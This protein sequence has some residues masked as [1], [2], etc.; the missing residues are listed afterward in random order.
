[1]EK[2]AA[3][4]GAGVRGDVA[5]VAGRPGFNPPLDQLPK[6]T[7]ELKRLRGRHWD[8]IR[9]H[10]LGFKNA[11]I[12]QALGCTTQTVSN[13]LQAQICKDAIAELQAQLNVQ[14]SDVQEM[15]ARSAPAVMQELLT[16]FFAGNM[17]DAHRTK[18]GFG[19]MDRAGHGPVKTEI[20]VER[21][22]TAEEMAD[23]K[24]RMELI[25]VKVRPDIE[26]ATI[27]EE[28][29]AGSQA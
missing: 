11:E 20:K 7:W 13:C 6:T 9:Y 29:D 27:I 5:A 10:V 17:Q 23:I 4:Y 26:E 18:L 19:I 21:G 2:V 16:M 15:L 1:M 24:K 22:M 25:G 3:A 8:I 12:A 28:T 14:V